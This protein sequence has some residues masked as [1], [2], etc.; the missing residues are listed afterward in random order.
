MYKLIYLLDDNETTNFY[1][2]DV[3]SDSLPG[4]ELLSFT[5]ADAFIEHYK[6]AEATRALLLLDINM[7]DKQGFEVIETLEEAGADLDDLDIIMVSSSNLKID[8]EKATRYPNVIGFIE[9]P[10]TAQNLY[11][12]MNGIF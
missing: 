8:R 6:T 11:N 7:P 4:T 12:A 5:S 9:K 1:H 2:L 3:I 10:L